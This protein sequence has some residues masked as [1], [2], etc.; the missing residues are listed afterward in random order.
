V[1]KGRVKEAAGAL[2][3]NDKLR[4]QGRKD[5][6][7]G[8][9]KKTGEKAVRQ[10]KKSARESVEKAKDTARGTTAKS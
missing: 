3:G 5:Q 2:A 9:V 6:A 8:R 4:A 1:A 7:V 10:V